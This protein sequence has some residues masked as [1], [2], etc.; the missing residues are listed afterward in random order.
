MSQQLLKKLERYRKRKDI[1]IL[2][3]CRELDV[4]LPIKQGEFKLELA[5]WFLT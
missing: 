1:S 2:A 5:H 4:M 3:L